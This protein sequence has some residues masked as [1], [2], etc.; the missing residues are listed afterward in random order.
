M[1]LANHETLENG[2]LIIDMFLIFE[3]D[4][5]QRPDRWPSSTELELLCAVPL[6]AGHQTGIQ[7]FN[8]LA[9]SGLCTRSNAAVYTVCV[10][11]LPTCST[12]VIGV[13][14]CACF[15]CPVFLVYMVGILLK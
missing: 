8:K 9:F 6:A 12:V 15:E 1:C 3:N 14:Y 2:V 5:P 11:Q 4:T 10:C 7:V 13:S